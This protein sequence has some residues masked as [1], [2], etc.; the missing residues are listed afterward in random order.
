MIWGVGKSMLQRLMRDEMFNCICDETNGKECPSH[1]ACPHCKDTRCE[2]THVIREDV[3]PIV[4]RNGV[5]YR[6]EL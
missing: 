6:K 4:D 2:G 3:G 5:P 1:S